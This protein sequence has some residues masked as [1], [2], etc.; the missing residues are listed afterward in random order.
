[1]QPSDSL[2]VESGCYRVDLRSL[3]AV[4]MY[5]IEQSMCEN[6]DVPK[7]FYSEFG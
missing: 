2:G 1:M 4:F 6:K 7:T 5:T 3:Y